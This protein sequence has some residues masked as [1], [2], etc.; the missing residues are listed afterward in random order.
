MDDP[1][2]R[3]AGIIDGVEAADQELVV[4]NRGSVDPIQRLLERTFA[5]QSVE[6]SER[7]I[8]EAG[9]NVVLLVRDGTVVATSSLE[10]LTDACLLV[11]SDLYRT[12]AAGVDKYE[13]PAVITELAD[14]VFDLRGFPASNREK[15]LLIIVS[16]FIEATALD[17][18]AGTLHATFQRLSRM[19]RELGTAGVYERLGR[20]DLDVHV[21]GQDDW[22]PPAEWGLTV[23]TGDHR[24]YRET[25]CVVFDPPESGQH[26]A[27]VALE[28]GDNEWRGVWTFDPATTHAVRDVIESF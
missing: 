7:E 6:V 23:H 21:Y 9:D 5:E 24:G 14:T 1:V 19:D 3:L 13:A 16:R 18:E 8:P 12:G 27:L 26:A 10:A 15:L 2:A 25:W 4:V 22:Q 17:R 28:T 20:T 11:N